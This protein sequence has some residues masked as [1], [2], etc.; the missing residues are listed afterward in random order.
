MFLVFPAL[1][2]LAAV[3]CIP[4][5]LYARRRQGASWLLLCLAV[6]AAVVWMLLTGAGVGAQ[7]LSNIIEVL[8]LVLL[9]VVGCYL[10]IFLLDR[11]FPKP[12]RTSV[13]LAVLVALVG[14]VLRLTMPVL[15]E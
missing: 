3:L 11:Y 13:W 6:P 2:V 10:Q 14:V 5:W 8:V 12:R 1:F 7:S 9:S 15:P 4:G